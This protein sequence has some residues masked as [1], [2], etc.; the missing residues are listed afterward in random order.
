MRRIGRLIEHRRP[1]EESEIRQDVI[2]RGEDGFWVAA[3]P[4]LAGWIRQ[5]RTAEDAVATVREAIAGYVAALEQDG[6]PVPKS[7]LRPNS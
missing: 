3:V 6:L 2:H 4:S 1:A 5:G 7:T